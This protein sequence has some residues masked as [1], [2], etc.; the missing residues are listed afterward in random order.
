MNQGGTFTSGADLAQASNSNKGGNGLWDLDNDGEP[1]QRDTACADL[2]EIT[3]MKMLSADPQLQQD[4]NYKITY[5]VVVK[6]EN[7]LPVQYNLYDT[8]GYDGDVLVDSGPPYAAKQIIE[9][10][11]GRDVSAHALTHVHPDHQGSSRSV[12]EQLE[13][14]LWC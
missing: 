4:G 10:L 6:N 14:A 7:N 8:L 5:Q 2:P 13:R 11:D 9:G 3:H 1:D 12:C